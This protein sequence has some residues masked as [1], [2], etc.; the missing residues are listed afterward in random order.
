MAMAA[1]AEVANAPVRGLSRLAAVRPAAPSLVFLLERTAA[2]DRTAFSALYAATSAK[3]YGIILRILRRRD[4]AD[5]I[6][7]EVYVQIW[8][9]AGYYDAA[10]GAPITW[11]VAIARN[12]ALDEVRRKSPISI[13]DTPEVMSMCGEEEHPLDRVAK[14][15]E[16]ARLNLCLEAL[17]SNR[18]EL[19]LLAYREG[20][21]REALG[22]R[23][24]RPPATIKSWLRRSLLQ[25]RDCLGHDRA[26]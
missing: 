26:R 19:V 9:R 15:Q 12:R 21:S 7:Q 3:L 17:D 4:I 2:E 11:M 16:L 10:K 20:L 1:R 18:R 13:E 24:S 14:S 5:E 8:E 23:F 6:L 25:L 22:A